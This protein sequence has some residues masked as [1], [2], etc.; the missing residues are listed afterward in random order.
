VKNVVFTTPTCVYGQQCLRVRSN[1]SVGDQNEPMT[2]LLKRRILLVDDDPDLR[3]SVGQTLT[4]AG[5]E[6]IE[7]ASGADAVHRWLELNG[8]DLVILDLF[9][10]DKD[11]LEAIVELR[12]HSPGVPIIATLGGGK[13]EGEDLLQEAKSLGATETLEKPF[14][15]HTLLAL[16]AR[17]LANAG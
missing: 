10:P 9:M 4:V 13:T 12:A 16:V 8:G 6:V 17:A 7:A 15:A 11:G 1:E 2:A 14:S 3:S 5:Y